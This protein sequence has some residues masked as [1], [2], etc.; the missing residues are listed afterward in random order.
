MKPE[1]RK[2][3]IEYASHNDMPAI[4]NLWQEA[5]ADSVD[6]IKFY[7]DRH[8]DPCLLYKYNGETVAMLYLMS[9]F[10]RIDGDVFPSKYIYA[11]CTAR[12]YR[13]R[14]YMSELIQFAFQE[15]KKKGDGFV[16]LVPGDKSLF[17]YYSRMGFITA[18]N[19]QMIHLDRDQLDAI[20]AETPAVRGEPD[21]GA[22]ARLRN[23]MCKD[24]FL[25]SADAIMYAFEENEFCGGKNLCLFD[26]TAYA[27]VR[28]KKIIELCY[29]PES[30]P[31][32]VRLILDNSKANSF[33]IY[34]PSVSVAFVDSEVQSNAML[35]PLSLAAANAVPKITDA[36]FGLALD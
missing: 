7:T 29:L 16:C 22:L 21:F 1:L 15:S 18:F 25:W 8:S 36:Y 30:F 28:E 19:R 26:N 3:M 2:K 11:A 12:Q 17:E 13:G 14:G 4:I 23:Y 10:V 5:F 24:A 9:G 20:A 27:I 33:N 34:I 32:I 35:Y 6:Y 31:A